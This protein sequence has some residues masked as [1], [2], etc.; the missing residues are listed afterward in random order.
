MDAVKDPVLNYLN[1][2]TITADSAALLARIGYSPLEIGLLFSQPIIKDV[3]TYAANNS[4]G[5]D[6]AIVQMLRKYGGKTA[7]GNIKYEAQNGSLD[8]L[9]NNIIQYENEYSEGQPMSEE[10]KK[11]QLQ[12]LALFNEILSDSSDVNSFVQCTRFTAA[13][14]IG[15]TFG[16]QIAQEERV[17]NFITKYM[18]GDSKKRRLQF[19]LYD[20]NSIRSLRSTN[21]SNAAIENTQGI[22]NID[23]SLLELSPEEY[24]AQMARNPLAFEQCM[25]DLT[26]KVSKKLFSK[27]VPF[28]TESYIKMRDVMRRLT[29]YGT[30][31][32]DIINALHK[33]FVVYMLANQKGSVFDGEAVNTFFSD[34][35]GS[36]ITNREYY[37][38]VFPQLIADL[39]F[40]SKLSVVSPF[41]NALTVL[42]VTDNGA[43]G[44]KKNILKGIELTIQGMGGLQASTSNSITELWADA[45]NSTDTIEGRNSIQYPINQLA[46][47]AYMYCFY[48]LGFNFHPTS[49]ITLAPTAL[50][51][52]LK[53]NTETETKGY[54]DFIN[55]VIKGKD[56]SDND[57][58]LFAKQFILNHPDSNKFVYT[59]S[60]MAH[61][62]I[63]KRCYDNEDFKPSFTLSLKELNSSGNNI[64]NLF[65]LNSSSS[66][67]SYAFKPVIAVKGKSKYMA[68]NAEVTCYYIADSKGKSFNTVD[69]AEGTITY[70]LVHT[71][72]SKGQLMQYFGAEAYADYQRD[73][74]FNSTE[75]MYEAK[76][77]KEAEVTE[78]A[79]SI[80]ESIS[81]TTDNDTD[82]A[83]LDNGSLIKVGDNISEMFT[84]KEWQQMF[85]LFKQDHPEIFNQDTMQGFGVKEFKELIS[86][87]KEVDN[88]NILN[89]LRE[90]I[91]RGEMPKTLDDKGNEIS[92]CK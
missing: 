21:L 82:T 37:T 67:K 79:S 91:N 92:V 78:K 64:G 63:M 90:R 8:R 58:Y 44:A 42:G 50:K 54:I 65:L 15:S 30:L 71:Q 85:D 39:S 43:E 22:L 7:I 51:L 59:P 17:N 29:K 74:F 45:I 14:S 28:Y 38:Q 60:G 20:D 25:M 49:F 53:V 4:T 56:V 55:E 2:N 88:V 48:K 81:T 23:E 68:G 87:T 27:N 41:F 69:S 31:G 73:G 40:N 19:Q 70:R 75:E 86:D 61:D 16:D 52:A 89:K 62:A 26:R 9:A 46:L 11:N 10:F 13:N 24:M 3:C 6:E 1:L 47:D 72:G 84:D 66:D 33:E 76:K 36:N 77:A 18:T 5:T 35:L 83:S 32:A 57:I 80:E 34:T 12:I